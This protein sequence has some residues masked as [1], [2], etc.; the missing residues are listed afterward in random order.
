[1]TPLTAS[2]ESVQNNTNE[3]EN[4]E[5]NAT[6]KKPMKQG[7]KLNKNI[8]YLEVQV[9]SLKKKEFLKLM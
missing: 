5:E 1:V 6:E 9:E 3:A 7:G 2:L 4:F 8:S